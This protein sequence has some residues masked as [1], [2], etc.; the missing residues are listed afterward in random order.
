MGSKYPK[1]RTKQKRAR[2]RAA[3]LAA[4]KSGAVDPRGI[5]RVARH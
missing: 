3:R 2:T 5:R 1:W 4:R